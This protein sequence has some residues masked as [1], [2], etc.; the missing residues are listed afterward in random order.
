MPSF[1]TLSALALPALL[2]A[3]AAPAP[4]PSPSANVAPA[5]PIAQPSANDVDGLYW[6]T[7]TRFQA[8]RRNCPH[9]G[10]VTLT[11][12]NGQ[13]EYRWNPLTYVEASVAPDG[14]VQGSGPDVTL[15][16]RLD[17]PTLD[18]D[19]TNGACGLHFTTRRQT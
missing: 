12:Q 8:D 7:S 16:G 4:T 3:C 5:A 18:G 9:P 6:G 10:L 15:R 17:G 13:F 2:L 19:V 11:V 1:H 14:S